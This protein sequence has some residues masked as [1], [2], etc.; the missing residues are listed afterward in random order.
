MAD[1]RHKLSPFSVILIMVALMIMGAAMIPLLSVQLQPGHKTQSLGVVCSWGGASPAV[2]ESEVI[3]KLEGVLA[4]I[5]GVEGISSVSNLGNGQVTL[6]F[7]EG[8]KMNVA[9]FEAASRIRF[10]YPKLPEGVSYPYLSLSTGGDGGTGSTFLVGYT[11]NSSL[12]AQETERYITENILPPLS[13]ITDVN[14]VSYGGILPYEYEITVDPDAALS[15][16]VTINQVAAAFNNYFAEA[17]IGNVTYG[18][19]DGN[20]ILLKARMS[21][22]T[23]DFS[24]IPVANANGRIIYIGD[25]ATVSFRQTLP[26]SYSRINGLSTVSISVSGA[27]GC[28]AVKVSAEV[29]AIMAE[30][31]KSFPYNFKAEINYDAAEHINKELRTIFMRTLMTIVI[32]ML[33]VLAVSRN[34]RYLLM[35]FVTLAANILMAFIFYYLLGLQIHIYSLAGITVSLGIIIDTS[36]I[37]ID[38]YSYYRDRKAFLAILAAVLTSI[39]SMAVVFLLPA[40]QKLVFG[41]FALVI[42]LNLAVSLLIS[43][44]FI[45]ALLDRFP[46]KKPMTAVSVGIKR[47][48]ARFNKGYSRFIGWGRRH[49]WIFIVILILG[50]GVPIHML[51]SKLEPKKGEEPTEWMRLYNKSVGGKFYRENKGIF[52]KTLGGSFRLFDTYKPS[53]NINRE[54]ERIALTIRAGMVEGNTVHQLNEIVRHM[55]NY[56]SQFDE[57]ES[58]RTNVSS[59]DNSTI[60]VTF[61]PE[62][63][64]GSFP[65]ILFENAKREV[66]RFGGATWGIYGLPEMQFSN[67]VV[68]SNQ[69]KPHRIILSGYNYENLL[70][71][72]EGLKD[73][74]SQNRR[75]SEPGIYGEVSWGAARPKQEYVIDIDREKVLMSGVNLGSYFGQLSQLLYSSSLRSV[76]ADGESKRVSLSSSQKNSFDLWHVKNYPLQVD[77]VKTKLSDFGTVERQYSGL[78][79]YRTNQSYQLVV[80]FDFIG[81]WELSSRLISANIKRMNEEVLPIG[82]MAKEDTSRGYWGEG[83]GS[84]NSV[85]LILLVIAIIYV[86]CT[87]LFESL[88]KP[89]VIILMI[90][91]SFIG[92]FLTFGLIGFRFDQG[93]FASFIL[94]SGLVINAGIYVVNEFNIISRRYPHKKPLDIYITAYSRKIIPISLTIISTILGMLP[95]I[96]GGKDLVFWYTFAIGTI[97]GMVFS[98]IAFIIYLPI[99]MPLRKN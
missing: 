44:F 54:P 67:N 39:A 76:F 23:V 64:K 7:K 87:I 56:L 66:I 19:G 6:T 33:F 82:Y 42:M 11:I 34:W 69:Y 63:E 58:F 46:L 4:Q 24:V 28:N 36:I 22:P 65:Y 90:P 17:T 77:T 95:F 59:Y 49:R 80:A 8:T 57:I 85:L 31:E 96:V 1:N 37:M 45:P 88:R 78:S 89:L 5:D 47:L 3:S 51:P 73:S 20:V 41:D 9:R 15:A 97:G 68:S 10:L 16:G 86:I 70:A 98:I 81:S 21:E 27:K 18:E 40:Q 38:H 13:R 32:L 75:V 99:F 55:E 92:V 93:G 74:L 62:Y 71:Y 53:G 25:L 14:R 29:K 43:L 26:S 2:M 94:L 35:I 48:V 91:V 30:L 52:E 84:K 83:V 12:S 61:K 79:I 60:T 50:F 72:A